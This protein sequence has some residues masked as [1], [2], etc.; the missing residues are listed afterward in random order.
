M[1]HINISSRVFR[2]APIYK[3]MSSLMQ[4]PY[5]LPVETYTILADKAFPLVKEIMTPYK[6]KVHNLTAAQRKFNKHLSSKRS[7]GLQNDHLS[8]YFINNASL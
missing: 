1:F 5:Q 4:I 6:G 2:K 8:F 3:E 7:V